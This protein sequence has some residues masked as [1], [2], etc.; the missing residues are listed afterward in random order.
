MGV[1]FEGAECARMHRYINLAL[2]HLQDGNPACAAI[3]CVSGGISYRM[4]LP[5][6]VPLPFYAGFS[7][8]EGI[9][10]FDP[11]GPRACLAQTM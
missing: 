8:P 4:V 1:E 3:L 5:N 2:E 11:G 9:L 7:V 6:G 10:V